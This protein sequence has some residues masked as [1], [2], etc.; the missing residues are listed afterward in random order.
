MGWASTS[1]TSEPSVATPSRVF[2]RILTG[3]TLGRSHASGVHPNRCSTSVALLVAFW[4]GGRVRD[5]GHR[6][7][8]LIVVPGGAG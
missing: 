7:Q 5:G 1:P 3:K 2:R 4:S 8:V 6:A